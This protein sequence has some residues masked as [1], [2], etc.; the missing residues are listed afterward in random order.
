MFGSFLGGGGKV[1]GI[2]ERGFVGGVEDGGR[3]KKFVWFL[4]FVGGGGR[5]EKENEE[6]RLGGRKFF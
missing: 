1:G 2:V 3:L 4:L 5:V 6:N